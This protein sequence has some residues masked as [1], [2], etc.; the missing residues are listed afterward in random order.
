MR[1][2]DCG[3]EAVVVA[4][5]ANSP[6]IMGV[7]LCREHAEKRW[8]HA[9]VFLSSFDIKDVEKYL[10]MQAKMRG[11]SSEQ[12]LREVRGGKR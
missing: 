11:K 1:C 10:D 9:R 2:W 12:L 5:D 7:G 3:A 6:S 8:K 4:M